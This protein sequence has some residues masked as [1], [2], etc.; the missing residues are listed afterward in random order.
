MRIVS[1]ILVVMLMFILLS[2]CS[3]RKNVIGEDTEI[4]PHILT[5]ASEDIIEYSYSYQNN[6]TPFLRNNKSIVGKFLHNESLTLY[7]FANLPDSG[8]VATEEPAELVINI[9]SHYNSEGLI[10]HLGLIKQQWNHIHATWEYAEEDI[11]WNE[12]WID[13]HNLDIL[14]I[15]NQVSESDSTV[16]F[17]FP[18]SLIQDIVEGWIVEERESYGLALFAETSASVDNRY[19]EFWSRETV[20]AP[21][22]QFEYHPAADDT[23][24]VEYNRIPIQETFINS[25]I[26][27]EAQFL[28]EEMVLANLAPIRTVLKLN[29]EEEFFDPLP[30]DGDLKKIT[31]N[32]AELFLFRQE[33]EENYH[34]AETL[35]EIYPYILQEEFIPE[36]FDESINDKM[37]VVSP[38]YTSVLNSAA[39][40]VAVNIT[41]IVQ[42][43]VSE[44]RDNK[45]IVLRSSLENKDNSFVSFHNQMSPEEDKRP[46]L[47]IIY[48]LPFTQ[49]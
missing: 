17:T 7:R 44:L 15:S 9:K 32:K 34:F 40:S 29:I 39:D 1:I 3:N 42:S 16:V 37:E 18:S 31:V 41:S 38:S 45:G 28:G 19:L 49:E 35:F 11:A 6:P 5:I 26:I 8:F 48:T 23:T 36:E 2:G 25:E 22:L 20:D 33:N 21:R 27:E 10:L 30:A 12:S 47:R 43:Y 24:V 13:Y 4:Q 46:Y 14:E